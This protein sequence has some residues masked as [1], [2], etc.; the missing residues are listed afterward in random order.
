MQHNNLKKYPKNK[1]NPYF[2]GVIF[3]AIIFFGF[4]GLAKSS[5]AAPDISDI[6]SNLING[7]TVTISGSGFGTKS[8][9]APLI[10]SYNNTTSANNWSGGTVGGGWVFG[11]D[12]IA[13]STSA[14][15]RSSFPQSSYQARYDAYYNAGYDTVGFNH[16]V[17]EDKIYVSF[18]IYRNYTD[19]HE[20]LGAGNNTKFFRIY[21]GNSPASDQVIS[22]VFLGDGSM[23][24]VGFIGEFQAPYNWSIA[25]NG[26]NAG[27]YSLTNFYVFTQNSSCMPGL[28]QW[29]HWEAYIDYPSSLGGHDGATVWWKNGRTISR[30]TNVALNDTGQ[31]NDMRWIR[32]GEVSG[33]ST[34]TGQWEYLDQVYI[35][36]TPAH[37]FI[38]DNPNVTW[39]DM[40]TSYHSE[41]QVPSDWSD[42]SITFTLNQ[43]TFADDAQ[44][45]LYV[46]DA[47]GNVN[48]NGYPVTFS[49]VPDV[50]PPSAP[51]GLSVS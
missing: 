3:L 46:V 31:N 40:G 13:L 6:S 5:Q 2:T 35:D 47:N 14:P 42:S 16:N 4:F 27:Q 10:S 26:C 9:A 21:N 8:Q 45:Y 36:N 17:G 50:T 34:A 20:L 41:I 28:Q 29:E 48:T 7:S 1:P 24:S 18:W 12:S 37:V 23:T 51:T 22:A 39:P 44:A 11:G 43:G 15:L 49:G 32:I 30:N 19:W 25:Y 33:G 38:S